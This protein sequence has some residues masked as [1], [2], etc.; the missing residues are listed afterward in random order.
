MPSYEA[1]PEDLQQYGANLSI[2]EQ[3]RLLSAWSPLIAYGQRF[4]QEVDPYKK[5][6]VVAEAAEWLASKT[7]TT[8]DDQLA[9]LLA[10]VLKTKEGE[11][12]VRFLLLQVGGAK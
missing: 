11:Q 5:G 1:T 3:L 4:V 8:A 6:L 2:W 7:D 9:R 12:L 10:D